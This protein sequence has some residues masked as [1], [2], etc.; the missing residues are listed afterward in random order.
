MLKISGRFGALA[1]L[2]AALLP[3][4]V[5]AAGENHVTFGSRWWTQTA[6]E[7][8]FR[9]YLDLSRGGFLESFLLREWNADHAL[10]LNGESV[11]RDD[12]STRLRLS[13]GIHCM[14]EIRNDQIPHLFS[15]TAKTPYVE[16]RPGE[17]RLPDTLQ[18]RIPGGAGVLRRGHDRRTA[19][20]L[21]VRA[22]LRH[23]G[24]E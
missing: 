8:A 10:V 21:A 5:H 2:I 23:R 9:E 12:Q 3:A 14:V 6:P 7:A 20:R 1:I 4:A 19:Q 16:I 13:S 11:L 15:T 18:A 24:V 22:G 17:F